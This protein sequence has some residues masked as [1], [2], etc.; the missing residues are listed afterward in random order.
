MFSYYVDK[1]LTENNKGTCLRSRDDVDLTLQQNV[2]V[3]T[4][5]VARV[6]YFSVGEF[7]LHFFHRLLPLYISLYPVMDQ[8]R[9]F[10]NPAHGQ[11]NRENE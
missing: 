10:A 6:S 8:P 11:L 1:S 2:T 5:V 7:F 9:K 4:A 3:S